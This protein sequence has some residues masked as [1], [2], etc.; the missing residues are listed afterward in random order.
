MI[1]AGLRIRRLVK[2]ADE[3][4]PTERIK[5]IT[6]IFGHFR[7]LDKETV[8]TPWRVV[9]MHMS[10]TL[11]GYCFLNEQF[12]AKEPLENPRFVDQGKVT[13]DLFANPD[14][15][16]LEINSKSGLYP[17]YV[18]YSIYRSRLTQS[19]DTMSAEEQY[20]VWNE[21]LR[22]NV[23][24]LCKTRMAEAITRRTLAGFGNATVNTRYQAHLMEKLHSDM[25]WVV[26]KIKNP[27]SWNKEGAEMKFDAI[28]GNPPYQGTNHQQVYPYFYRLAICLGK[29]VS[30]IFPVGWQQPR[31]A[32]NLKLLN[33]ETIKCDRQIV[34]INNL[35]NVFPGI[36]GA[37]WV[38]TILWKKGFD[39]GL[40][41]AQLILTNGEDPQEIML[42][43]EEAAVAKPT[44]IITLFEC[45]KNK[46]NFTPMQSITSISK[47][48]GIR[49]DV[50]AH[51]EKYGL[52][53]MQ[54]SRILASDIAVY[55]SFGKVQYI[56]KTYP[57][58]RKTSAFAKY[59]VF[60]GSAWGNM[61]EK[62]GLGGAYADIIVAKP[63]EICTETY[64]ESG[65]YEDL[66][67]ARK[68]AKYLMTKFARALLYVNKL[69][70]MS[71]TAW[72]AVPIQDF[73]EEWWDESIEI[74]NKKLMEKYHVPNDIVDFVEENIQGRS[75]DNI[76]N[77]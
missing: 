49:K 57:L 56:P 52:P 69:S 59:K 44:Q 26:K 43:V 61:S 51:F 15:K 30:M 12:D 25:D 1:A 38:N 71:T 58:P 27:E 32:N 62:T 9:N 39:N 50:F 74:I 54:E 60:V 46:G 34:R 6:E 4:P 20:K 72:G 55:G 75:E 64:Q 53:P 22:D 10:D 8:L 45:V 29:Y 73:S 65:C 21:V 33:N 3:Y 16:I 36:T 63:Y 18:A 11:G 67:S 76:V 31:N 41:G 40:D 13:S 66:D 23:F 14:V 2:Q 24:V 68:Q 19:E 28:V 77:F 7:N 17:L 48:Y 5:R 47:P 35:Q 42:P 37:E 70:Q